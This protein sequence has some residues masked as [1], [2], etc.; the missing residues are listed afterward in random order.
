MK[1]ITLSRISK[2]KGFERM[3]KLA[4]L[5]PIP[6]TWDVY[7]TTTGAYAKSVIPQFPPSVNFK[8]YEPNAKSFI[9][10]YDYLVQLSDTEGCPYVILEALQAKTP[11]ITTNYPSAK[12]LVT[13]GVTG[14]IL[15]M[16]LTNWKIILNN[17]IKI[18]TFN[19]KST[20]NDWIKFL[21]DG[22]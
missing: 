14:H 17:K 21:E 3:V 13:Q 4:N 6:F 11:V 19:P 1:L 5:I 15:D 2:E 8:G 22:N 7:G 20:V 12:E 18:T 9:P 10:Q 16:E